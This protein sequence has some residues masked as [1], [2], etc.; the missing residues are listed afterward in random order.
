MCTSA[1]HSILSNYSVLCETLQ[2]VNAECHDEFGRTAGG[3][4]AQIER[5]STYLGLKMYNLLFDA[6]EQISII[7]QGKD[8]T[9]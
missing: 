7:L 6:G 8:T 3:Y 4:L 9:L 2:K 1:L 5:F